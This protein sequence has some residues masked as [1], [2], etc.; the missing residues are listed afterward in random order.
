MFN[1]ND[2]NCRGLSPL[3]LIS[4]PIKV[5]RSHISAANMLARKKVPTRGRSATLHRG[6]H[7]ANAIESGTLALQAMAPAR[8]H[9][10]ANAIESGTLAFQRILW[11]IAIL[12]FQHSKSVSWVSSGLW[13]SLGDASTS[14]SIPENIE[15]FENY[16]SVHETWERNFIIIDDI[17]AH[18][19]VESDDIE[20]RSVDEWM[21]M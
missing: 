9:G 13:L 3:C 4:I 20:P 2:R 8:M 21:P 6:R 1:K 17:V 12:W 14:E 16:T 15:L 11:H 18:E 19:S 10:S 7:G 5:T